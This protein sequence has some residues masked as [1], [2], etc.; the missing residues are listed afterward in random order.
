[1]GALI[2]QHIRG[3]GGPGG[4][5]DPS[6]SGCRGWTLAVCCSVGCRRWICSSPALSRPGSAGC[7]V[8]GQVC[9]PGGSCLSWQCQGS[10][11]LGGIR[12]LCGSWNCF[13]ESDEI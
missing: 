11:D 13:V 6:Q 5:T 10:Q 3:V 12:A 9:A 4:S 1:M 7:R 8:A 2:R